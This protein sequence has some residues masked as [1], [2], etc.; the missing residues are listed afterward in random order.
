MEEDKRQTLCSARRPNGKASPFQ[1][2]A[3]SRRLTDEG[4]FQGCTSV[5]PLIRP[6]GPPSPLRGEGWYEDGRGKPRPYGVALGEAGEKPARRGRRA[7]HWGGTTA[8][9]RHSEAPKGP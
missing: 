3:V 2:E 7:P 4:A 5:R 6:F 9:F 1:G 8:F